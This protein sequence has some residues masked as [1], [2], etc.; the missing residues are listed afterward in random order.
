MDWKRKRSGGVVV[1]LLALLGALLL[2]GC[3]GS[4]AARLGEAGEVVSVTGTVESVDAS[5]MAVDGPAEIIL[6]SEEHGDVLVLVAACEGPCSRQAVERLSELEEGE[7]WRATGE[8]GSEGRLRIDDPAS[9]GL[10]PVA[11]LD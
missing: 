7:V 3:G 4:D 6:N 11:G 9:H 2:A 1:V 8:L 5:A 10:A